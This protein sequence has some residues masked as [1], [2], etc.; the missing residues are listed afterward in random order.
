MRYT[1]RTVVLS[2]SNFSEE[3]ARVA[4]QRNVVHELEG[5][6]R[7]AAHA[8]ALL[9]VMEHSLLAKRL[10]S[11][12]EQDLERSMGMA[13]QSRRRALKRGGPSRAERD[14]A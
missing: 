2:N 1:A 10:I 14:G 12:L 6:G 9:L 13:D 3:E 8:A 7:P 11:T 5:S 4:L